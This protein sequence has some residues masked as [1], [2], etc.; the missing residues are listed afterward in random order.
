MIMKRTIT[1]NELMK[2]LGN[3]GTDQE[4]GEHPPVQRKKDAQRET[5]LFLLGGSV[6]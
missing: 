4:Q 3:S 2:R 6:S 1:K 5:H